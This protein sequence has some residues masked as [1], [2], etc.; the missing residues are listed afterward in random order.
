MSYEE[1]AER[2]LN[3]SPNKTDGYADA[4]GV[5]PKKEYV[6]KVNTNEAAR[7]IRR[8]ELYIG[9]GDKKLSLGMKKSPSSQ[10]PLNQVRE[11]V[12]GHVTEIDDT[13]GAERML[14]KHRTGAGIELCV[15]GSICISTV[16][17]IIRVTGGDEKVII[18]GD[19]HITYNGNLTLNVSGDFDLNV[20]G[21][22]NLKVAGDK[23]EQVDGS[24]VTR[25]EKNLESKVIKN[26]ALYTKGTVS[27]T[28][29]GSRNNVIKENFSNYVGKTMANFVGAD[30]I[31]TTQ[32]EVVI[33]SP[34]INMAAKSLTVIGDSGT[35]GG[36]NI[37]AY[38]YNMYTGHSITAGDT[39]STTTVIASETMTSPEFI[40]SL[41]GNADTAT[42]A[43][44]AGTAGVLGAGGS[45]GAK[46][47]G[48]AAS[49][50]TTATVLPS[51]AIINDY[52]TKSSKGVRQVSIDPNDIMVNQLDRTNETGGISTRKLSTAEIRSKLR[53]SKTAANNTF[54]TSMI[55]QGLLN[56]NYMLA[57]PSE[58]G[59]IVGPE[60]S[61]GRN[62][63][64]IGNGSANKNRGF[65]K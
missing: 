13:P 2:K 43:G 36:E 55:A 23:N 1:E 42:Q 40:G 29:L 63:R 60:P 41:T 17:N 48:T 12:S 33:T 32:D 57:V 39:V 49:V 21:D 54:I 15:D 50:N 5:Y 52:T 27:E 35:M 56:S 53:D 65:T 26:R 28:I 3:V 38:N 8:N 22:Y 16:N 59:R 31:L 14:F 6:N 7:G 64:T 11:T 34:N 51:T 44:S 62:S 58:I 47:T 46:V 19:G 4:S 18:E 24:S 25:V 30:L 45:A 9:G 37:I 10:Y 61:V 20:G